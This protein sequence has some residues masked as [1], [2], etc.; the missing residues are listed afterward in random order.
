MPY[1]GVLKTGQTKSITEEPKG[2]DFVNNKA[3]PSDKFP[4]KG[5]KE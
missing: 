5:Q 3:T 4:V 1:S 2:V